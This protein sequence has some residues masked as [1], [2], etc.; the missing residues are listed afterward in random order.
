MYWLDHYYNVQVFFAPVLRK[1]AI[2]Y[3]RIHDDQ[4][5]TKF[6]KFLDKHFDGIKK[7]KPWYINVYRKK[8]RKFI[9][10]IWIADF[11]TKSI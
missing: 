5:L 8:D 9:K 1:P 2:T 3:H 10:R 6:R 4:D 7:P 11:T